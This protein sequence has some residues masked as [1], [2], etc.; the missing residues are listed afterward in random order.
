[1]RS[2]RASKVLFDAQRNKNASV[3]RQQGHVVEA[4]EGEHPLVVGHSSVAAKGRAHTLVP[5]VRLHDLADGPDGHLR[6]KAKA[7]TRLV[8]HQLLQLNLVGA[9][10]FK[11]YPGHPVA[12]VVERFHGAQEGSVL[13][14]VWRQF[15]QQGL[16]HAF[17]I[18]H[19]RIKSVRTAQRLAE[20]AKALAFPPGA[21]APG[22]P[23][24]ARH[25]ELPLALL[26]PAHD[27]FRPVGG[28]LPNPS[29]GSEACAALHGPVRLGAEHSLPGTYL[30]WGAH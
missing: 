2:R 27:R 10:L 11:R 4:L 15:Y 3:Q 28:V 25:S 20:A 7:V 30:V 26:A 8:V 19:S 14:G 16:L 24:L 17:R 5:L 12:S 13:L 6:R 18:V 9:L 22:P 29:T 1:M 23:R 21:K